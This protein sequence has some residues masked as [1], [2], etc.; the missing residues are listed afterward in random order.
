MLER[1][2]KHNYH[3]AGLAAVAF[4]TACSLPSRQPDEPEIV[5]LVGSAEAPTLDPDA[6]HDPCLDGD[7]IMPTAELDL[8]VASLVPIPNIRVMGGS[9]SMSFVDGVY[10]YSGEFTLQIELDMT[11]GQ[12]MQTD[13]VFSSG[14]PY[15]TELQSDRDSPV[16]TFLVLDLTVSES[17]ELVWRVYKEGEVQTQPGT[18]PSFI[19]LPPGNAPYFCTDTQLEISTEGYTGPITM[20]FQR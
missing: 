1:K 13:A 3:L 16:L 15:A 20:F 19:I 4:L 14:G 11:Q 2:R 5:S 6:D 17:N 9:L 10:A 18:G 12:Y 8:L 7:W